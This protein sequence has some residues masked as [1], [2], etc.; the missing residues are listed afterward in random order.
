[1][2]TRGTEIGDGALPRSWQKMLCCQAP[3]KECF[4]HAMGPALTEYHD[5]C[6]LI[7]WDS[8]F[9]HSGA[10]APG[11]VICRRLGPLP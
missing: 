8:M 6:Y 10:C 5:M 2:P 3:V 1:M 4:S 9:R 7:T 11:Q